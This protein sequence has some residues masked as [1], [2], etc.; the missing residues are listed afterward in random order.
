MRPRSLAQPVGAAV[1][2]RG[3]RAGSLDTNRIVE[4]QLFPYLV[5]QSTR[6]E[7]F[8]SLFD[9]IEHC[10]LVQARAIGPLVRWRLAV[11]GFAERRY[12]RK[13][14]LS[15]ERRDVLSTSRA[16]HGGAHN[17]VRERLSG[18]IG[19]TH[20]GERE[21]SFAVSINHVFLD[22]E[23]FC[24]LGAHRPGCPRWTIHK[25]TPYKRGNRPANGD[26]SHWPTR[27]GACA[28][29]DSRST[30]HAWAAYES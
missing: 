23:C 26:V 15:R 24:D 28:A 21:R 27:A 17:I 25:A 8:G 20:A 9:R 19:K 11:G 7:P 29:G 30:R 18:R 22:A 2:H 5:R 14:R 16:I 4:T 10:R 3:A 13:L 12:L 1:R 6:P